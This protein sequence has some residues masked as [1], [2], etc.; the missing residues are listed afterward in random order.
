MAASL[1]FIE[2]AHLPGEKPKKLQF[3]KNA[4][5]EWT[6]SLDASARKCR[7]CWH[8]AHPF[9]GPAIPLPISYDPNRALFTVVGSFC[10]WGCVKTFNSE[11]NTYKKETNALNISLF[12]MKFFG[13]PVRITPAPP[14]QRLQAFGGD[15]SIEEFRKVSEI[16]SNHPSCCGGASAIAIKLV[17][18]DSHHL[19]QCGPLS[20]KVETSITKSTHPPV[21]RKSEPKTTVARK[22][23]EPKA[24]MPIEDALLKLKPPEGEPAQPDLLTAVMGL[25]ITMPPPQPPA[26]SKT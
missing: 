15:M 24:H 26:Q 3:G 20:N 1:I 2:K 5:A 13:K 23:K 25:T 17:G 16:H 10:S 19:Q 6:E 11:R 12:A 21:K 9:E 22:R 7:L 18:T 14:R 8:C 4:I